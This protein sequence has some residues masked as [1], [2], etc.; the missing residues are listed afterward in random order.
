MASIIKVDDVQDAAGNNIINESGD[1]ITIGASGDTIDIPSGATL[2]ATGAT[3]TGALTNTPAFAAFLG[4]DQTVT[5]ATDTVAA[6]NTEIF[7]SD[8][9]YDTGTYRFTPQVAGTYFLYAGAQ[10]QSNT[11][12][13]FNLG[14]LYI[15]KNGTKIGH[16]WNDA[17]SN[18]N[19]YSKF[20]SIS[21]VMIANGSTDY[22]DVMGYVD[23]TS[24]TTFFGGHAT[25]HRTVFG[26][27]RIIGA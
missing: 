14:Q 23:A 16:L 17:R 10:L 18:A 11:V 1:V 12:T 27:Y 22:F 6:I 5:D 24:G 9:D 13:T 15:R 2:D 21:T 19:G 8:S 3:I 20:V 25:E 4:A 7:D 26:G